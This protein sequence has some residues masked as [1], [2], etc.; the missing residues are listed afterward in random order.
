MVRLGLVSALASAAAA[1]ASIAY[2]STG[3]PLASV[4]APLLP[5]LVAWIDYIGRG[6]YPVG[7]GLLLL[8]TGA[9]MAPAVLAWLHCRV[10]VEPGVVACI[11][12][13]HL[14]LEAA[15]AALLY[16]AATRLV[17]VAAL[18]LNHSDGGGRR[19]G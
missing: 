11:C 12:P 13:E 3:R 5:P 9:A 19:D 6:L 4:V 1:A 14:L 7:W 10:I 16:F 8:D 17:L 15:E 2:L 18:R